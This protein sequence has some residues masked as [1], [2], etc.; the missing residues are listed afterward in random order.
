[1]IISFAFHQIDI[2][3]EPGSHRKL[4]ETTNNSQ[5]ITK[6]DSNFGEREGESKIACISSF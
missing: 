1:M 5:T 3:R 2:D 4:K 6:K